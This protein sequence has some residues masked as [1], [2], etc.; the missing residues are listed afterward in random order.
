MIA[1]GLRR[2]LHGSD[3]ARAVADEEQSIVRHLAEGERAN[4]A[5]MT[6]FSS[7]GVQR[8][9][10]FGDALEHGWKVRFPVERLFGHMLLNGPSGSGKSRFSALISKAFLDAGHYRGVELDPKN[11]LLGLKKAA[12][13]AVARGLSPTLRHKLYQ[14]VVQIDLFG[15][16]LPRLNVLS[17]QPGMDP[18]A[19]AY[20]IGCQFTTDMDQGAGFRQEG[21]IHR[22]VECLIRAGLPLTVM[23][24]LLETPELLEK[25]AEH[26]GPAELFRSLAQRL[27]RE[28]KE[29]VLGIQSR[30]ERVLRL[31]A[32]RLSL[33][34]TGCLDAST[35]LE[36]LANV[37]LAPPPSATDVSKMLAGLLWLLLSDAIRRRPNGSPPT[38]LVVDEFPTFLA[39]GGAS[40]ADRFSDLVRLARAKGVF[41]AALTQDLVSISKISP[42]L[43]EVLRQNI[44]IFGVFRS[45]ADSAW[46]FV[47]PVT[48]KRRKPRAPW[49][50]KDSGYL[51]RSAELALL[52]QTL[53]RLPDRHL[54][55][56]DRRTGLPG[57]HM[58]TADF[59]LS[60]TEDEIAE[61]DAVSCAHPMLA[62]IAQ[63]EREHDE[64]MR[65]V[66]ELLH[67]A[68]AAATDVD[69]IRRVRRARGKLDIG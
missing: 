30:F 32:K 8:A 22:G 57:V 21:L 9:V 58:K 60:V 64:V 38:R 11:E 48:G 29:R 2:L 28:S 66:H 3:R 15:S 50:E 14:R 46:D 41:L 67:G 5:L 43:T 25:L 45:V 12:I 56:A 4:R 55:L 68:E 33:G 6:S 59:N 7:S 51:E 19:H 27:R 10:L 37:N 31:R 42:S 13:I 16:S 53:S 39:A 47:L 65:R 36:Q 23:P 52:R 18:E 17:L 20:D 1:R 63:L 49:D 44:H 40:I 24:Q 69:D 62:S 54:F 61:L 35:L 34:A 26:H